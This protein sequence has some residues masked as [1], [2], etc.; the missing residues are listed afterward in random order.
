MSDPD[1]KQLPTRDGLKK[2]S[3]RGMV[4]YALRCAMR[5]AHLTESYPNLH[6]NVMAC[7]EATTRFCL[8]TDENTV[9]AAADAADAAKAAYND[10]EVSIAKAAY[11]ATDA[12]KAAA[13]ADAASYAAVY[14]AASYAAY[15]A[16]YVTEAN[17]ANTAAYDAKAAAITDYEQLLKLTGHQTGQLGD[18]IDLSENGPLGSLWVETDSQTASEGLSSPHFEV[19][20]KTPLINVYFDETSGLGLTEEDELLVLEYVNLLYQQEGRPG[21]KIVDDQRHILVKRKEP[22]PC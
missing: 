5:M 20:D 3:R 17:A 12:A 15:A 10:V 16:N 21:L 1:Y 6:E 11:A 4:C 2:L 9:K 14:A 7:L 8:A 19:E 18:P 22:I 13:D